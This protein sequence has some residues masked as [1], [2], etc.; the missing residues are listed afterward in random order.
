MYI[1]YGII[2]LISMNVFT[3][4]NERT[5]FVQNYHKD[6]ITENKPYLEFEQKYGIGV[7]LL[8]GLVFHVFMWPLAIIF[9]FICMYSANRK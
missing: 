3:K 1:L 9:T 4:L 6:W 7:V 2:W 5:S 8:L